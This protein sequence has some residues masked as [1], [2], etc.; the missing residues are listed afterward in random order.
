MVTAGCRHPDEADELQSLAG[1]SV[2]VVTLDVASDAS[3]EQAAAA[4]DGPVDLLVNNAGIYG[5]D[6]QSL[7]VFDSQIAADVYR[8]NVIG[9]VVLTQALEDKLTAD[10][11]VLNVSS[12]YG[13]IGSS[14]G[15]WPLHYCP[16]KAALNMASAI[17]G[18]SWGGTDR[19]VVAMSPGWV[20]TDMGGAGADLTPE[21]SVR[22]MLACLAERTPA[23]SGGFYDYRGERKPF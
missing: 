17:I 3:I 21:E 23:N 13:S 12:G 15:G 8:T 1:D 19:V 20:Q 10:A 9:P 16:S 7:R 2:T 4:I 14:A 22:G 5:G 6:D 11:R 18:Q